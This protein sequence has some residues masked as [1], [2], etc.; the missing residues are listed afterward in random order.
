MLVLALLCLNTEIRFT[1]VL[2][3]L[4][5]WIA[6]TGRR[7]SRKKP[8]LQHK[9]WPVDTGGRPHIHKC[10]YTNK[11]LW[12]WCGPSSRP[13]LS[14]VGG[15][16]HFGG[17]RVFQ[18]CRR[19]VNGAREG[20]REHSQHARLKQEADC[21]VPG[22]LQPGVFGWGN[23]HQ[24]FESARSRADRRKCEDR[25]RKLGYINA[26]WDLRELDRSNEYHYHEHLVLWIV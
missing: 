3:Y 23:C 8:S 18:N 9:N 15:E 16:T 17:S 24:R 26:Q 21:Q 22:P 2:F 25:A 5:A 1:F 13:N 14:G 11:N 6:R 20:S 19:E 12:S 10:Q 7:M 4:L